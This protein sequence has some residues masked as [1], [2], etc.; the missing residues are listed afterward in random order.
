MEMTPLTEPTNDDVPDEYMRLVFGNDGLISKRIPGYRVRSSQVQLA[1]A[2]HDAFAARTHLVAEAPTGTG[3]S[4]AYAVPASWYAAKHNKRVLICT[5]N[6]A[7]Q[8]Q[9]VKKD[10]PMLAEMLPWRLTFALAKGRA[11]YLCALNREKVASEIESMPSVLEWV[12]STATGDFSELAEHLG[13]GGKLHDDSIALGPLKAML[14]C[15]SDDCIGRDCS[16]YEVDTVTGRGCFANQSRARAANADI[17]VTNYHLLFAHL[18]VLQLTEGTVGV[19]PP[20]DVIVWDEA[21]KA[22]DIARE[23]FGDRLTWRGINRVGA[24][25]TLDDKP[26]FLATVARFFDQLIDFAGTPANDPRMRAPLPDAMWRPLHEALREC[27]RKY[28]ARSESLAGVDTKRANEMSGY[29]GRADRMAERLE[30]HAQIENPDAVYFCDLQLQRGQR[31]RVTLNSKII[32]V[33]PILNALVW[34]SVDASVQTSATLSVNGSFSYQLSETGVPEL[35]SRTLVVDTPF[36]FQ[37]QCTF[38]IPEHLPEPAAATRREWEVEAV[39][40]IVRI[41]RM[42][43][44]RTLALFTTYRMLQATSE[45]F[46]RARVPFNVLTQG[47][48]AL[49]TQLVERFRDDETSVLLGTESFW[50]GVDVPGVACSCVIIDKFPFPPPN[51]PIMDAFQERH[52][53]NTFMR[54]SIPRAVIALKQGFGRLIRRMDDRGIVV[55]LDKRIKTKSY[56]RSFLRSLPDCPHARAV[57][58][59]LL[60]KQLPGLNLESGAA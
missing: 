5:A 21:H 11:N 41:A 36:D 54:H 27:V 20:F 13:E 31:P 37:S 2:V 30:A 25:L 26:A 34:S 49:R 58:V 7:L 22:A 8:E 52:G 29:A 3:K 35:D 33:A 39:E 19:L 60:R 59:E 46:E 6:I 40:E 12:N 4:L 47:E 44:G 45:A 14:G 9:L 17:V 15:T 43:G 53:R 51:D 48:A 56:G 10:L 38:V 50:A 24:R 57:T 16:W 55:F 18:K 42:M 1:R 28:D 32:H 23:F